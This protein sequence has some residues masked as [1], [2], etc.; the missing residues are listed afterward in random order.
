MGIAEFCI[1]SH[2]QSANLQ[3]CNHRQ[4][5]RA[6]NLNFFTFAGNQRKEGDKSIISNCEIAFNY[7]N[8]N[9]HLE[10]IK[11]FFEELQKIP[12]INEILKLALKHPYL[13]IIFDFKHSSTF[14]MQPSQSKATYVGC[15]DQTGVICIVAH[16]SNKAV[17]GT[18]AHEVAHLVMEMLYGS[19][20][21][22]YRHI[23]SVKEQEFDEI[24]E[25]CR[26]IYESKEETNI[27]LFNDAFR[28]YSEDKIPS[29][30]I[31]RVAPKV[32][33]AFCK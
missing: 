23:D 14:I 30:L 16:R 28:Y 18:I 10:R 9:F 11:G 32:R 27:P 15:C 25:K 3:I 7:S 13:R 8:D 26:K 4:T 17:Q 6:L 21:N 19:S 33:Y 1:C 22:P 2:R 31:A 5:I 29:E 12:E 24:K 20:F